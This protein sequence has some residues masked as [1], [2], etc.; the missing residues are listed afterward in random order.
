MQNKNYSKMPQILEVLIPAT[1]DTDQAGWA[2][3]PLLAHR[4]RRVNI[5]LRNESLHLLLA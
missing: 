4:R 2:E 1:K 3:L 5:P